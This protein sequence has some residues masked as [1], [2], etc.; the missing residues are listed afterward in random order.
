MVK[1]IKRMERSVSQE[2]AFALSEINGERRAR[3]FIP[4][5]AGIILFI[6]FA[7]IRIIN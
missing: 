1:V 3:K 2:D 7:T 6:V 5:I 4:L